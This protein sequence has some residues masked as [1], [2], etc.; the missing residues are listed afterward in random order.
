MPKK[1]LVFG[2]GWNNF[3]SQSGCS[4]RKQRLSFSTWKK[5]LNYFGG[6][7]K[8]EYICIHCLKQSIPI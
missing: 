6:I 7:K 2:K 5:K 4:L 1:I 3:F 8:S